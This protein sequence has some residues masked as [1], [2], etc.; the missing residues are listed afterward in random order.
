[1]QKGL[2]TGTFLLC[3]PIV[4]IASFFV[5]MSPFG[6]G[7]SDGAKERLNTLFGLVGYQMLF[8]SAPI[9]VFGGLPLSATLATSERSRRLGFHILLGLVFILIPLQF[10]FI[11]WLS[12]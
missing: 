12:S 6:L 5:W 2:F 4:L 1:M 8:W 3:A 9:A 10:L 7:F 11:T